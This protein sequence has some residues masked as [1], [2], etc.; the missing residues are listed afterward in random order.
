MLMYCFAISAK[1]PAKMNIFLD[2]AAA[3]E[4]GSRETDA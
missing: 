3:R 2:L 1:V 4:G